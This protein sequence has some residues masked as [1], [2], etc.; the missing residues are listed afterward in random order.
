MRLVKSAVKEAR[1]DDP[2]GID[3][4][5]SQVVVSAR[6]GH[7]ADTVKREANKAAKISLLD[8]AMT[9]PGRRLVRLVVGMGPAARF[10]R[11]QLRIGSAE[12]QQRL[13]RLLC[14][15]KGHEEQRS[16]E[17]E[18]LEYPW[19]AAASGR[20]CAVFWQCL[21]LLF[22]DH[23]QWAA[24]PEP[25]REDATRAFAGLARN[26]GGVHFLIS[27]PMH[28]YPHKLFRMLDSLDMTAV[29]D[30]MND[31]PELR[32][33][34]SRDFLEEFNTQSKLK[35]PL[36]RAILVALARVMRLDTFPLE[37]GFAFLKRITKVFGSTNTQT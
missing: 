24:V 33:A 1:T 11:V 12:H 37:C 22:S 28:Q 7:D 9:L 30:I 2:Y 10:C 15:A 6:N 29:D 13:M 17:S 26:G 20:Y 16:D 25:T 23:D 21:E 14:D 8:W 4:D 27:E 36:A 31:C 35:S 34:F 5:A 32:D 18:V 3:R 19:V